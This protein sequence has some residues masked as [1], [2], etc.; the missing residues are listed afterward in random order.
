MENKA[1]YRE[2]VSQD[3]LS[4]FWKEYIAILNLYNKTVPCLFVEVG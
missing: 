4:K 2:N 1:I 3:G